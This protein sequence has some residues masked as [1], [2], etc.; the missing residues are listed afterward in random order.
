MFIALF[1]L[2]WDN[3]MSIILYARYWNLR[4]IISKKKFAVWRVTAF[5]K[6]MNFFYVKHE[7]DSKSFYHSWD[8]YGFYF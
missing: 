6:A 5:Q 1:S 3:S 2:V 7:I 8:I 4:L